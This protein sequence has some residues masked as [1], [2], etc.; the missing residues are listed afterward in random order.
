MFK[1]CR[2]MRDAGITDPE[3][4]EGRTFCAG[5][6]NHN[7]KCP[8]SEGCIVVEFAEVRKV[9]KTERVRIAKELHK[10]K[11]AIT[12]I[13]LILGVSEHTARSYYS[14]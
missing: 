2:A 12:D 9:R 7:S 10:R 3:S 13:A 4:Q 6:K 14:L 1:A 5:D 8:Y 11:V